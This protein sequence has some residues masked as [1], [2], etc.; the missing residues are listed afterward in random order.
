MAKSD[1]IIRMLTQKVASRIMNAGETGEL[2]KPVKSR[3]P[4]TMRWFGILP[5]AAAMWWTSTRD[6]LRERT[7][8]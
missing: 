8:K 5:H 7:K 1:E 3:E 2:V 4:W 6:K